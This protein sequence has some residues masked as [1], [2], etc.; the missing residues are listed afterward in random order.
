MAAQACEPGE[1]HVQ[2]PP[3]SAVSLA[4]SRPLALPA[5][6]VAFLFPRARQVVCIGLCFWLPRVSS[7]GCAARVHVRGR[8]GH[9]ACQAG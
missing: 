3:A 5:R 6:Q 7:R 9:R 8:L 2:T 1:V 4:A